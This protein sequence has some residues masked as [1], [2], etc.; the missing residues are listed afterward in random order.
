MTPAVT[1]S[2]GPLLALAVLVPGFLLGVWAFSS[3]D[4]LAAALVAGRGGGGWRDW[5]LSPPRQAAR[6]LLQQT[7]TSERPDRPARLLAP[8]VYLGLAVA[9]VAAVPWSASLA[10]ADVPAGIVLW[11]SAE[12]LAVVAIFL[13]GWSHN[14]HL[15]LL[16]GYRYTGLGLSA[17]LISMFVLIAAAL[18]AESLALGAI[19]E[20]QRGLWNVV[21][22]PLGLPLYLVVGLVLAFWGPCD[23]ADSADLAGGTGGATSGP[24]RLLW[25]LAR[26]AMLVAFA[27]V[28][29][30]VFLG[31]WLAPPW[32]GGLLPG[33]AWLVLKTLLVLALLAALGRLGGRVDPE[34]FL[35]LCWL[36]L[37][38]ASFLGLLAAGVEALP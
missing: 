15:A 27:A 28:A 5:L 13:H 20:S 29:A 11:G 38:P 23:F 6:L 3:L 24:S 30:T 32:I 9:G 21:R 35:S 37:L 19:V 1:P 34:R 26:R 2:T 31:G 10:P 4:R 18:P 25:E 36:V 12:A 17:L 33:P 7:V 14:T 8:A 16:G 22:Q